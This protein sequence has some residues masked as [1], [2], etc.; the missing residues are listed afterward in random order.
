[1]PA[2]TPTTPLTYN[3]LVTQVC[4]LAPYQFSTVAGVVT[5]LNQPEFTQLI[6]Q[7]LNYAEQR[8]QRDMELLAGVVMR[9]PY[10]LA[11][12]ASQVAIPWTDLMTVEDLLLTVSGQPTPLVP[13]SKAF[14]LT[15]WP[16]SSPPGP[17]KVYAPQGGDLATL[18]ATSMILL[19]GPP[20]DQAYS[21]NAIGEGRL[22]TLGAFANA[23]DAPTATTFISTWLPDLLVVACMIYV[24]AYQRDFGRQSDD[25][26]MAQSY[27]TQYQALLDGA[28]K[29][30]FRRR[31]E[32][33]AWSSQAKS[34]VATPTR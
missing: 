13:V 16:T 20:T 28:N 31:F 33:D 24:S 27:E 32:A 10:A 25:P 23:T 9:G 14:L 26:Q 4:L 2:T 17:P 1:M 21:L 18:G 22:P 5:P 3:G 6:P 12:G 34:P 19:L 8:I 7:M 29:E 15:V 11:T 30:E